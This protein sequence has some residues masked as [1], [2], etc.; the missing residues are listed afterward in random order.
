M[1]IQVKSRNELSGRVVN[2]LKAFDI[3]MPSNF[4]RL[5]ISLKSNTQELQIFALR[6]E[7]KPKHK[8]WNSMKKPR[9]RRD[10]A[11]SI[12]SLFRDS[13]NTTFL[14]AGIR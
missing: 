2:H 10:R 11:E 9:S 7:N 8:P 12:P 14:A 3:V 5:C 13:A 6:K 4:L 1:Q